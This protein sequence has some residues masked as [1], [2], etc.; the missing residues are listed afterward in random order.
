MYITTPLL[1]VSQLV[2]LL[3]ALINILQDITPVS[4][5]KHRVRRFCT[6]PPLFICVLIRSG[7]VH[8]E[9]W[10]ENVVE[11]LGKEMAHICATCGHEFD[12]ALRLERHQANATS[13][14]CQHC[15]RVF[16]NMA[17]LHQHVLTEHH[18]E[19]VRTLP[20]ND[21]LRI[22]SQWGGCMTNEEKDSLISL[23]LCLI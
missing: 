9:E 14:P 12:R 3:Q 11:Q 5:L 19:G 10:R 2:N 23:I 20:P 7:R 17:R 22:V 4:H 8:D 15:G 13:T 1:G 21:H 16:C 18:G 6:L